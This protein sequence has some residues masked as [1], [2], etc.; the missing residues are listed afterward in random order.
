MPSLEHDSEEMQKDYDVVIVGAGPVG[1]L[2]AL[3]LGL[4]GI[5]TLLL[6]KQDDILSAARAIAYMPTV[7]R[8]FAAL[9]I[10]DEIKSQSY[11]GYT[12]PSWRTPDGKA[13]AVIG[14]DEVPIP[15][16]DDGFDA[17]LMLGQDKLARLILKALKARSKSVHVKFGS[18]CLAIEQ[19]FDGV[20]VKASE[21]GAEYSVTAKWLVGADGANSAVR[22]LSDIPFEGFTWENFRFTAAD[23]RYKFDK[24][25]GYR[26]GNFIVD[27][28][29]WAVIARTGPDDVWRIAY[30]ES[31]DLPDDQESMI[32]RSKQRIPVFLPGSK[33]YE[34]VRLRPY[35]A[36]QRCAPSFRK[37][38][39]L[40]AGDA[41]H[42]RTQYHIH[43]LSVQAR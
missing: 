10:Y 26:P 27:P 4:A 5:N 7:N 29:D 24:E 34:L 22:T 18:S 11:V 21:S 39:V 32:E 36:Q 1:L 28:Q 30:G 2:T 13:L 16:D 19:S 41:A 33:D 35:W 12:G 40:L 25:G 37:G 14:P 6:E 8:E 38:R 42:V 9:G 3:K 31:P 23:V 43:H 17:V 20:E 15:T